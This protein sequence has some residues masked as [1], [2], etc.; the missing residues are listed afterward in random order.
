MVKSAKDSIQ[1]C[2]NTIRDGHPKSRQAESA[3]RNLCTTI[4]AERDNS[5][6]NLADDLLCTRFGDMAKAGQDVDGS[7]YHMKCIEL[8]RGNTELWRATLL[9]IV[10][11]L[12]SYNICFLAA[13]FGHMEDMF[14]SKE[15]GNVVEA[16]QQ[17]AL[18][19]P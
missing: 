2:I 17:V 10:K 9:D 12:D 19:V 3:L 6:L 18:F 4:I 11:L 13:G 1:R 7:F 16:K 15:Q 14:R 8:T 5:W